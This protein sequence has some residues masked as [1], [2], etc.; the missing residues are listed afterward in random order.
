MSSERW[1]GL[2]YMRRVAVIRSGGSYQPPPR[3]TLPLPLAGPFGL[4]TSLRG[5]LSENQ[6][7]THSDALP[8]KS[9]M[10]NGLSPFASAP[11]GA[12]RAVETGVWYGWAKRARSAVGGSLPHG[13]F[14]SSVP[15]AAFSH[16]ASVGRRFPVHRQ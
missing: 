3:S 5:K 8:D 11:T 10:P 12:T 1:V 16:S 15:R 13:Y 14:R 7:A 4:R 9:K 2:A 6:S